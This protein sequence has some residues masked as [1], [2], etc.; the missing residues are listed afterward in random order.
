MG[1]IFRRG[2]YFGGA[3]YRREVCISKLA[4]LIIATGNIRV[5]ARN[6]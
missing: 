2:L 1:L 4:G 6:S 5:L 3:Y